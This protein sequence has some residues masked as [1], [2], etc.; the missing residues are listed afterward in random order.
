MLTDDLTRLRE[1]SR[2]YKELANQAGRKVKQVKIDLA[3]EVENGERLR[4]LRE[5]YRSEAYK[6]REKTKVLQEKPDSLVDNSGLD[7]NLVIDS[8]DENNFPPH[9]RTSQSI[10]PT[11]NRPSRL[12][13]SQTPAS[14]AGTTV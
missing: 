7:K 2:Q 3:K 12:P 11:T 10:S 14:T 8:D 6:L 9:S 5:K 1:G 13:K 4:Q